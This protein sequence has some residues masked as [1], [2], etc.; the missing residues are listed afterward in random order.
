MRERGILPPEFA[1]P[2]LRVSVSKTL[3]DP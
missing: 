2:S 1:V 3:Q